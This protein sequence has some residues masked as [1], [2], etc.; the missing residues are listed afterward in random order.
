MRKHRLSCFDSFHCIA[1]ACP[2]TCCAGWEVD[3]DEEILEAYLSM[4]GAL[5]EEL[6]SRIKAEDGYTYFEME[7]GRCPFLNDR[8]LCRLILEAGE[9][10]L[11][12]TCREHPRFWSDY[13]AL[14]ET[15]LSIS[16]PEAARLLFALPFEI[17]ENDTEETPEEPLGDFDRH[18]LRLLLEYRQGLFCIAR[19]RRPL[20][21]RLGLIW[22][23]AEQEQEQ[24]EL[25]E[26][27]WTPQQEN[28]SVIGTFTCQSEAS[29]EEAEANLQKYY[30]S[31]PAPQWTPELKPFLREMLNMEF[32]RPELKT[33]LERALLMEESQLLS[34]PEDPAY[35]PYA[36]KL[37]CY[38]LYRYV[39]RGLWHL[40]ILDKVRFCVLGTMA[41]LALTELLEGTPLQRITTAATIFSREVE[42][43]DENL[44]RL[45][46]LVCTL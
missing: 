19:C 27:L 42:H 24:L 8:N 17:I 25:S 28:R 38:F 12:T 23:S 32:T 34:P 4:P 1:D 5:G 16:C 11:S 20:S 40:E 9:N 45:L 21:Q 15:C 22:T 14:R 29:P 43:S 33:M 44:D 13:G 37:L 31:L 30:E 18:I 7:Q 6:R 2:D 3:L 46:D 35:A 10:C 26:R 39:P 41:V 36:E